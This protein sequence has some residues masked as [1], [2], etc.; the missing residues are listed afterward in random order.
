MDGCEMRRVAVDGAMG[1]CGAAAVAGAS[2]LPARGPGIAAAGPG[3][4][5][6]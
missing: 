6:K 2:L 4:E 1:G 3:R 5:R